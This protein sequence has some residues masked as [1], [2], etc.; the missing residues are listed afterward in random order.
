MSAGSWL[1]WMI[2]FLAAVGAVSTALWGWSVQSGV[3]PTLGQTPSPTVPVP[4]PTAPVPSWVSWERIVLRSVKSLGLQDLE[5]AQ[6]TSKAQLPLGLSQA[7]GTIFTYLIASR[8][9]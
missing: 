2:T 6:M 1:F 7:F 8:I 9:L 5:L 4:S 3:D